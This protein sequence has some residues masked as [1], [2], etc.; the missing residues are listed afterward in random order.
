MRMHQSFDVASVVRRHLGHVAVRAIHG[1]LRIVERARA[2][3][4]NSAGLPVIVFI[5]A[6][7]P[8]IAIHRDIQVHL[9]TGRTELRRV[10]AH[11]RLEKRTAVRLGVQ[12][13]QEVVERT[14]HRIFAS[15]QFMKLRVLQEKITLAHSAFHLHD[16]VAHQ[17]SETR[18][19]FRTAHNLFD[20]RIEQAAVEQRRI[21][22]TGAPFRRLHARDFLHVLDA[23]AVPLVVE[24]RKMVDGTIP[25]FV[26]VGVA[27][28][29]S[30]GLHEIF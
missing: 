2:L 22:A 18:A 4:R 21:V 28:L 13:N 12:A 9:V 7:N 14:D 23:L 1:R 29:A 3:S 20:R 5:E 25:L 16:A 8:A 24:R 19:G 15:R 10:R 27:A 6:A 17:A 11:E 26:D 30:I